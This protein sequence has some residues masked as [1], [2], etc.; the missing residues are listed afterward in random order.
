MAADRAARFAAL[1]GVL[2][3]AHDVGDHVI[4]TDDHAAMKVHADPHEWIP[5]MVG[6]LAT[7]HAAQLA[8]IAALRPFG[9]RPAWR[10]TLAA[11][12]LSAGTHGLLDRRWPVVEL[13]R[14]TGSARFARA[15]VRIGSERPEQD[16]SVVVDG[17]LPLHGPHLAD[18]AL[19]RA[20]LAVAAGI[21]A[22]GR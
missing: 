12:A 22:G 10:R 16:G 8:A 15:R 9:V 3:A 14:R 19:H 11:V 2:W 6:H 4:Q 5:G 17:P 21:L 13:L 7:Y 20:A 1:L 18:Q